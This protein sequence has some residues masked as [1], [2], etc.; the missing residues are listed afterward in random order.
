MLTAIVTV[1]F[2][3]GHSDSL[4]SP[5]LRVG[6]P[7]HGC[8]IGGASVSFSAISQARDGG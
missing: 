8:P 7:S 1:L 2:R 3:F 6:T 5:G 4:T